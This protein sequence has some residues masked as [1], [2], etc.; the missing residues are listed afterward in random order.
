MPSLHN[1]FLKAILLIFIAVFSQGN[2]QSFKKSQVLSRL[3]TAIENNGV[4][5]A[6]YDGDLDLDIFVVAKAK[7]VPNIR[8]THSKLFR[9]NG[10]GTF[11]DVTEEAGL[12]NLF[13]INEAGSITEALDGFKFGASWGDFNNDGF[14][15]IFFT[16]KSKIQ[17]FQNIGNGTF[18]EITQ[19]AGITKVNGCV[20]TSATWFDVNNDGFLDVYISTWGVCEG[21][22]S[23]YINNGDSTFKGVSESSGLKSNSLSYMGIP[24]DFN[25]DGWMDLYVSNDFF[26]PNEVFINQSGTSFSEEAALYGLNNAENDMG[27]AIG[28][29]NNDSFF[30]IFI[31]NIDENLL[32]TNQGDSTFKDGASEKNVLSTG[33]AWDAT[34]SDFDLDGDEDLFITNGFKISKPVNQK[35]KY[36]KNTL[37]EGGNSF[38]DISEE[39]L[40][41][42]ETTSVGATPFDY[43][44][45]GDL[46]LF[47]ANSGGPSFLYENNI[48]SNNSLD[49]K[50]WFKVMLE[51]TVSNRGAVG[52]TLAITT[53]LGTM[54]RY[55]TGLGFLSQNIQPVHF[56]LGNA[57]EILEVK[58]KWPS[59]IEE[60]YYNLPLDA[61]IR[62]K[63]NQG[64]EV[65]NIPKAIKIEGCTDLNSCNYNPLAT[66]NDGTCTYLISG[67]I[68]GQKNPSFL[69][70]EIYTYTSNAQNSNFQWHVLGGEIIEGQGTHSITVK[71]GVQ[72]NGV[73]T[74]KEI[75]PECTSEEVLL[76]VNLKASGLS[77]GYSVARL[78]NEALLYAIRNDFARPTVH[79]RNLFH[80]SVAIYD[81]WA[82]YDDEARPYLIGNS[83]H[84]F[85][86]TLDDFEPDENID[87]A[88]E[89]AMSYAAYRLL[90]HRFSNS[91][92][93]ERSQRVFNH[94][95]QELGYDTSFDSIDYSNG[96]AAAL[97]NYIA[98]TIID[99]GNVDGSREQFNYRNSYYKPVNQALFPA[100]YGDIDLANPNR[101][102]PLSLREFIDQ[103]GNLIPDVVPEFL[104]PEWGDVKPFALSEEDRTVYSRDNTTYNVYHD[105]NTPPF[106]NLNDEDASSEAYKWGFSMVSVWG[107]HLDPNNNVLWDISPK[108]IGNIDVSSLPTSFEDYSNFYNYIDGGDIGK[109]HN[110]NPYTN[111][112]YNTQMVPRGDY[113]R[114][115]AEFWADGPDSETPPGH[116]FT[117]LNYV[118]DQELLDKKLSGSGETLNTL[119]WDVKS[120][121]LLGGT[122]HDAAISAWSIK[123]WYDYVRPISAVRHMA[124]LGQSTNKALNNYNVAGIPLQEGYIEVI[125]EGDP[126]QGTEGEHLGKIKLYTWRGHDYVNNINTE[127]AGVGWILAENWWPYQRP[128]FVTPPFAGYVSG[129][130]TYSRAA[131]E[132]MTLMTG[133]AFF[134]GGM[135]E[136][137]AKKDEFLVFEKGPSVDVK[138]QWATYRDASDQCSLSRIW[139]GI[140]PPAD[141]I[142]GRLVGKQIGQKAFDFGVK[143]FYGK[144]QVDNHNYHIFPNPITEKGVL[145][146]TNTFKGDKLELFDITG[147]LT[148]IV[149]NTYDA[150]TQTTTLK[151]PKGL[152]SGIYILKINNISKLLIKE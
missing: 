94:L 147:A 79:A 80:T 68:S 11:T 110:L 74:V 149:K 29:Y 113:T 43:D 9:N 70:S 69:S 136:F 73:I 41:S 51:G 93:A 152:A 91:P 106:L 108:S 101:W 116:W 34:F 89:K 12:T 8:K 132:L 19:E 52:T 129:H 59:G 42:E 2:A 109:G 30:D 82:I 127:T 81:A 103:S 26:L 35:N 44:N 21:F 20:N 76:E 104:S 57:T 90:S 142:P 38:E 67:N 31:T 115:L 25:S 145:M 72:D 36:F 143:Y 7:D 22:Y 78:W 23:L 139:G 61:T 64:Y 49:D 75:S 146:I 1:S 102:Q 141:D 37:I 46:D 18:K 131:A 130:S 28:D 140:H 123:G 16:H 14:P 135:G 83:V 17:L 97:G 62:V 32:F 24:F 99:Y 125:E 85:N 6:D 33:W 138:L 120:Y 96:N 87:M 126:L 15:D 133:D 105:P 119:E 63:E 48:L 92:K 4:A 65:L 122:M 58:I 53:N 144:N 112:P 40:F 86:T 60:Q 124:Q 66:I 98:K 150:N 121:F 117:L 5:V 27:I 100:N 77:E 88:R 128:S 71:W 54:H 39:L 111:S 137:I 148:V 95:M 10:N 151:L 47:V 13:S 84:D 56:G 114:V 134:P 107:A 45:D 50:H 118:N 3:N 55:Y